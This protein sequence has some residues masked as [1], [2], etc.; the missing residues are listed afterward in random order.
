VIQTRGLIAL[1]KATLPKEFPSGV[2]LY[3]DFSVH[4]GDLLLDY[5][6]L[7]TDQ[8]QKNHPKSTYFRLLRAFSLPSDF[9]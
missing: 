5:Y 6:G 1:R 3:R 2:P 7:L 4:F 8:I 9:V